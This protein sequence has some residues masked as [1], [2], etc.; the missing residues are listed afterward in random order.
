M[1]KFCDLT[2]EVVLL[3]CR[4]LGFLGFGVCVGFLLGWFWDLAIWVFELCFCG[5]GFGMDRCV[6]VGARQDFGE[7]GVSGEF[8][9]LGVFSGVGFAVLFLFSAVRL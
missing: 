4:F 5:W 3:L 8:P 1:W 6:W 7:F 9:C 2:I